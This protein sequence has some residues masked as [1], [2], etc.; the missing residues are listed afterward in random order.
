MLFATFV[1]MTQQI[2]RASG[3]RY[4]NFLPRETNWRFRRITFCKVQMERDPFSR[5]VF[6]LV[7]RTGDFVALPYGRQKRN[8]FRSTTSA[9][10]DAVER[11]DVRST[12]I[13]LRRETNPRIR[14][15][16]LQN[17]RAESNPFHLKFSPY[18]TVAR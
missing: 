4:G 16:A 2:D 17:A 14:R 1:A 11:D 15:I 8:E 10:G 18:D 3:V 12:K 7:R 9:G 6:F 13:L 5:T